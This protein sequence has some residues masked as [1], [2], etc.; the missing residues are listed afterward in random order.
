MIFAEINFLDHEL[1]IS[2]LE[3]DMKLI[4]SSYVLLADIKQLCS[5]SRHQQNMSISSV[6][7][8]FENCRR[9]INFQS[10]DTL[11]H[12]RNILESSY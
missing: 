12:H 7:L 5:S 10:V 4:S 1:C 2:A 3:H 9:S 8:D 11:S 6:T